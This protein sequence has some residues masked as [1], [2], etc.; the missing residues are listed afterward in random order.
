MM[1]QIIKIALA[2][3]LVV[4]ISAC[5]GA[6]AT[7]AKSETK[8]QSIVTKGELVL[9][10]SGNM[11]PMTR[12][13][14][15]GKDAVG[16]DIDL[17]QSLADTM[18]VKLT[19]KILPLDKLVNAVATGE[20]DIVISNLTMTPQRNTEVLFAGPYITSGK[21]LVTQVP[22]LATAS[23]EQLNKA[24]NKMAVT[25][26]ST[27]EEFVKVA[28]PNVQA[29]AVNTQEEAITMIRNHE[30]AAFLSE[31]PV[32][33]AIINNNPNDKFVSVFTNLTYDPIGIAVAP[34]NTHL[35]NYTQNFLVRAEHVGL[36]KVLA[37]KWFK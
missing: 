31:Y 5:N 27:S 8:L 1:K 14:N 16:F 18:G 6:G 32:C 36:L 34:E 24:Q 10:T 28:M 15:D 37:D 11:T 22:D 7:P 30:V 33:K 13:I 19:I 4:G 2:L 21:C 17:A 26:G 29:V 25:K 23:K 12:S 3:A 35:L 20:V 9:G